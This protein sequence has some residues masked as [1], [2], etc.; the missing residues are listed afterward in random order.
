MIT[1]TIEIYK[2]GQ[3]TTA[4]SWALPFTD[5]DALDESL[6]AG[7]LN[8]S[9]GDTKSAHKPWTRWRLTVTDGTD[10]TTQTIID[11]VVQSDVSKKK[12]FGT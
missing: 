4:K 6:D 5:G 7:T 1:Y 8:I 12:R 3:W 9:M 2:D 11:R 10:N